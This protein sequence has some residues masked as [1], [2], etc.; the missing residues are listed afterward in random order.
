MIDR[1]LVESAIERANSIFKIRVPVRTTSQRQ[2]IGPARYNFIRDSVELIP[3]FIEEYRSKF[4]SEEK[5]ITH[6]ICHEFG[7][8]KESR[9]FAQGEIFPFYLKISKISKITKPIALSLHSLNKPIGY[10]M[11]GLIDYSIDYE[12]KNY[13]IKNVAAKYKISLIQKY[14]LSK[15]SAK[16][17]SMPTEKLQALFNL[18]I[19]IGY[20]DFAELTNP[21]KEVIIDY[22]KYNE[23]FEKWSSIKSIMKS[24]NFC[25]VDSFYETMQS[26]FSE[27]LGIKI[28]K[29]SH[30]RAELIA[31]FGSLPDFWKKDIYNL[32][33]L[34]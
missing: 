2:L 31:K 34:G 5:L 19:D 29:N 16:K 30:S 32:L 7:H 13:G 25:E 27:L 24:R 11:N 15:N 33:Y 6:A 21:E 14:L 17:K 18:T 22:Y 20:H 1:S 26:L 12:L 4:D 9:Y 10:I 23:L 28:I 3:I 8:A